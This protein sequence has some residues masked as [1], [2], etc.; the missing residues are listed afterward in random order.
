M[1]TKHTELK[2]QKKGKMFFTLSSKTTTPGRRKKNLKNEILTLFSELI[3]V[4][5]ILGD[6]FIYLISYHVILS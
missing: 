5:R 6:L 4:L 2:S 1:H 3:S